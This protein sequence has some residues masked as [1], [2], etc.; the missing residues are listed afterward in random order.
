MTRGALAAG[1]AICLGAIWYLVLAGLPA[2]AVLRAQDIKPWHGIAYAAPFAPALDIPL[3]VAGADT[4]D[5]GD[6]SDL[7]LYENDRRLGSAHAKSWAVASQGGGAYFQRPDLIVFAASDSSDPRADARSYR[8]ETRMRLPASLGVLFSLGILLLAA[9]AGWLSRQ[10][11]VCDPSPD[12]LRASRRA[13]IAAIGS[14]LAAYGLRW[15]MIEIPGLADGP[16]FWF[17]LGIL[18]A[19]L[20]L[21]AQQLAR[22]LALQ[23]GREPRAEA[24]VN[25]QVSIGA[26]TLACAMIEVGLGFVQSADTP[27]ASLPIADQVHVS[28]QADP[29]QGARIVRTGRAEITIP[30]DVMRRIA[31][32]QR[33]DSLPSEW[34]AV[35]ANIQGAAHALVWHG[36][37]HVHDA[38]EFRR[39]NGPFP[40]RQTGVM[41][42]LVLGD[43]LTY[44]YGV[45]AAWAYPSLLQ[46]LLAGQYRAE[47]INLGVPGAQS[48]DV[49]RTLGRMAPLLKP[50][51]V[52]YGMYLNDFL[53]SGIIERRNWLGVPLPFWLRQSAYLHTRLGKLMDDAYRNLLIRLGISLDIW[54]DILKGIDSYQRRLATDLAEMQAIAKAQGLPP[55]VGMVLDH[56]PVIGGRGQRI[57]GIAEAAMQ[58]AGFTVIPTADYYRAYNGAAL[59]VSRWEFHPN[60]E[61]H[62]IF[63]TMIA[64]H[65]LGAPEL[66]PFRKAPGP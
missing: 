22:W 18:T 39:L 59:F 61:A 17:E 38:D 19:L 26:I 11:W 28:G 16:L 44:G 65:L 6:G 40:P 2:G 7:V 31:R 45:D 12:L 48:E 21:A 60:E 25:A 23:T 62:A 54:D 29:A 57:A 43:S 3:L 8:Y 27:F 37:L 63:A 10:N 47:V 33:L 41:R 46:T 24:W 30:D 50:D 53:P 55:V 34:L 4:E 20:V 56:M 1:A 13:L 5:A 58:Q 35:P 66:Q 14:L 52:I 49:A 9:A 32:A 15:A 64:D 42:I 36:A 51:L